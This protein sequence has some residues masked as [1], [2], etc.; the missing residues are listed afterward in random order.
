MINL[1]LYRIFIVVANKQNITNA[2]KI[3]NIS[4]PAVTKHIQNLEELLN[5][6]LFTRTNKGLILTS[7]GEELYQKLKEPIREIIEI[8]KQYAKIKSIHVGSHN[9]LL[10]KIFGK[11]INRFYLEYGNVDLNIEN[12]ETDRMLKMLASYELDIVFSKKVEGMKY[13]NIQYRKLG[14]LHDIFIIHKNM[15]DVKEK[16][17]KEMLK[18]KIIYVPRTYAQTVKRLYKLMQGESLNLRN[19]SYNTIL[20]LVSKTNAIGFITK[21]YIDK[22][23]LEKRNLKEIEFENGLEPVEFGIYLN[24]KHFKE[25]NGLVKIIEEQFDY[26]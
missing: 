26:K 5:Q 15:V 11:C 14:Y 2:S 19:S 6:K 13:K 22:E 8:D 21:E 17:Q 3:L 9:H 20:E 16:L 24:D 7:F 4:Q 18:D 12:Y 10:N 1:E 23:S 25:L